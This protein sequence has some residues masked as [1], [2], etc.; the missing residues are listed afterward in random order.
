MCGPRVSRLEGDPA[1]P[2]HGP[3]TSLNPNGDA[4]SMRSVNWFV[5]A[6]VLSP[7]FV[8]ACTKAPTAG[9]APAAVA[10]A[11]DPGLSEINQG[12]SAILNEEQIRYRSLDYEYDEGLLDAIDKAEAYLSG[13]L[14]EPVPRAM[15]KLTAEEEFD[16]LR[17]TIRRWEAKTGKSLRP[18]IDAL[19]ADVAAR[20]AKGPA[21]HPE[22][23]KK[24][25]LVFDEFIPIEVA[26]IRER[27]DKAIHARTQAL[28]DKY[29]EKYPEQVRMQEAMLN[30][31]S[32]DQPAPS[33][34]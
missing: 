32:S 18:E 22:F 2:G 9:Q 3:A 10:V 12:L 23:H 21:L 24:F 15:P 19:K 28:F 31:P 16:H 29:R 11:E 26:E 4:S 33:R 30:N 5:R 8:T 27:R 1:G 6:L 20:P 7:A 14:K 13:K 17:E 25:S 34:P